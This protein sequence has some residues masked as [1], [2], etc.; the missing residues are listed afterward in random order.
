MGLPSDVSNGI[1]NSGIHQT[2]ATRLQVM[3]QTLYASAGT[4]A[5]VMEIRELQTSDRGWSNALLSEYFDSPRVVTRGRLHDASVLPGLVATEHGTPV[6][7]LHYQVDGSECEVVAFIVERPR[8]GIGTVLLDQVVSIA[9]ASGCSRLW[10]VTTNDNTASQS[11]YRALGWRLVAVH[12]GAIASSRVLKP[13]IPLLGLGG[14]AIEDELEF[15]LD[16]GRV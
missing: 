2:A 11:F 14:V 1:P 6:G 9:R 7:L 16:V 10:L 4:G 5:C 12:K 8:Q 15:D 13:E 3:P